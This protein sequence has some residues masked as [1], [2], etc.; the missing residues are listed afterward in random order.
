MNTST[1]S[2]KLY[3][4]HEYNLILIYIPVYLTHDIIYN[5]LI[6]IITMI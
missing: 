2:L 3:I 4:L 1:I 6:A 5:I